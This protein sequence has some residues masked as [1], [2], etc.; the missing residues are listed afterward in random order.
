MILFRPEHVALIL[1]GLKT[2]TRRLGK[3][4]W[5]VGAVHACYTRPPFAKGG[6][7]PFC[8]VRTLAVRQERPLEISTA[9]ALAEGYAST[10]RFLTAFCR[11]NKRLAEDC[12][13]NCL[14]CELDN[15]LVW[16]V[17][18]RVVEAGEAS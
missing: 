15:P 10:T 3:R 9:D 13:R 7:E 5:K 16:V 8:R 6:A 2:Q 4:R 14:G 18:F 1:D 11:I 12:R 17:T